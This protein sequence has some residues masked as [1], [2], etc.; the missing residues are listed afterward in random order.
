MPGRR[1]VVIGPAYLD[2]ILRV[3]RPL[4][5]VDAGGPI[6]QSAEA[7]GKFGDGGPIEIVDP[8]G[9]VLE[10]EPTAGWPGPTGQIRLQIPIRAG[11]SGRRSL[12]AKSWAEDLGGM[13]AGFASALGGSLISALGTHSDP[14]SQTI[15]DLASRHGIDHEPIRIA[16]RPADWTLLVSS[17]EHGDKLPIGFRGCHAALEPG[18]L[19]RQ[20]ATRADVLVVAALPNRLVGPVLR[21]ATASTRFLAPS[22]RNMADRRDPLA[23]L[24]DRVDLLSC[25]RTE[26]ETLDDRESVAARISIVTITDGPRGCEI[27]F[28]DSSGERRRVVRPAF[29]RS[30]PPR[31]T[32]RAGEAFAATMLATL[33]DR[34]WTGV[35]SRIDE[36]AIRRA[37]DRASAA[38]ALVLDRLD[39]GFPTPTEIDAALQ[40]SRID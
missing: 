1:V 33:L 2:R 36:S 37:T 29:P 24:A 30:R 27:R 20:A 7:V 10:I 16:D 35:S 6:D 19:S 40:A 25:N 17:G 4:L 31:D 32:N 5:P 9:F 23:D 3:D 15:A 39:F 28:T 26:W 22:L 14:V 38:A 8:G 11:L 34:G 21:V 12:A 18:E 13:G